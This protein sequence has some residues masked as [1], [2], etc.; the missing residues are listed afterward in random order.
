MAMKI[1]GDWYDAGFLCDLAPNYVM[2][3]E[4][5]NGLYDWEQGDRLTLQDDGEITGWPCHTFIPDKND[6]ERLRGIN[7]PA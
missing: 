1:K 6:L 2:I 3:A 7:A 5:E 4:D